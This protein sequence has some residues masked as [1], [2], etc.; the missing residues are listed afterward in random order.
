MFPRIVYLVARVFARGR[1]TLR[2]GRSHNAD[3]TARASLYLY[4]TVEEIDALLYLYNTVEE[5][6]ALID[7]LLFAAKLF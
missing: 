5:I 3:A 1:A 4:N 2:A 6:D 7:G